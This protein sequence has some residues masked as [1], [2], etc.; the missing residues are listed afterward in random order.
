MTDNNPTFNIFGAATRDDIHVG[1]ISTDRG[2][3]SNVSICEANELAKKDPGM[4][5]IFRNREEIKYIN[6]NSVNKLTT[7]DLFED[8]GEECGIISGGNDEVG[9]A[10]VKGITVD[11]TQ[12]VCTP[13]VQ[14]FGGGGLGVLANP[15]IGKDGS[16]MSIDADWPQGFGY[17]YKPVARVVDPCGIG[18]GAVLKVIMVDGTEED[19][20]EYIEYEDEEDFED[21]KIC[22]KN[23]AGYGKRYNIR[24]SNDG[25]WNPNLYFDGGVLTFEQQLEKYKDFLLN[26]PNPW[27]TTRSQFPTKTTTGTKVS[28]E[29]YD[30]NHWAWGS[31]PNPPGLGT[32][33]G[34][35][36]LEL[37]GRKPEQDGFTFWQKKLDKGSTEEEIKLEM[38]TMPEY[39]L[40]QKDGRWAEN[41]HAWVGGA[42]YKPDLKNF[43][44]SY[45]ISPIPMSNVIPSDFGGQEHYFEWDI[46]FP[47]KGEY[48]FR[49]QCDNEG[50]LYVDGE[51]Q[52]DYKLGSGGAGGAVLSPPEETK[53]D[54]KKAGNHKIR[55]DLFNG[56]VMKKVAEQQ[57]LDALATSDEV[58]FDIQVATLYGASATIEG[59]DISYGKTYGEAKKV[60][61]SVTKKVEYGRVY[62]VKITSDTIRTE[63]ST[64]T[65]GGSYPL[66]YTKLKDGA[67]RRINDR[68]LEYD[69]RASNI[70]FDRKA[71]EFAGAFT[72]DNV[73]GGTAKFSADGSSVEVQGDEVKVTLTYNWD[74][75]PRRSGRVLETIQIKDTVWRQLNWRA[76]ENRWVVESIGSHTYTVT[77]AGST[78]TTATKTIGGANNGAALRTKGQNVLQMEDIPNT[79]AG[80]GGEGV[81]WDDVII[82]ASQGRFFDINGL[83]AKYT[84]GDRPIE[85]GS[86]STENTGKLENIFNTA[87]Y[88]DKADRPL[89]K[90]N[91]VTT[92]DS[93]FVNR[94]GISPFDTGMKYESS[95]AGTY[96]IKWHNVKFPVSGEYD[97]GIGVDDNVRLRIR[98]NT[99]TIGTQV[100][101]K[102]DGFAVRG[103][104]KTYTG[105]SLYRRFIEAGSYT[106]EADLEQVEG[107]DL[108]YRNIAGED[109]GGNPMTLAINIETVFSESKVQAQKSWNQNPLGV[110]MTIE[111]PAPPIPQ[112]LPPK[113][114]G[115]CPPNPF[116]STRYPAE[117]DTWY[118]FI[119]QRKVYRYAVSPV[120]PYG[121]DNTS[122]GSKTHSNTWKIVAPYDGFYKIKAAADDSAVI[123]FDGEEVLRTVGVSSMAEHKFFVK[124]FNDEN[125]PKPIEHTLTV[126]VSNVGQ[127]IYDSID[128]RIFSTQGWSALGTQVDQTLNT[129]DVEFKMSTSTMYGASASIPELDMSIEKE[130]GV[131]K[132]V[133][134]TFTRKVEFDR[135]Y[136]VKIGSNTIRSESSTSTI[137]GSYPL[138]YTKLKD[139]ALRRIND[140]RLE[141]DDR[142]SN[143]GFDRKANE[144]AGAFT[145]DNVVGGT[146]KFS[147]DGSSVE[148]QGDEVKVTL[149][150][151]W[152]DNPR[153]SGRVLETIAI[154]DTVWRQLN[155]RESENRWVVESIGSHTYTVTLA[156]K[157]TSTSSKTI[158]GANNGAVLR[159]KG[160]NVLQM[161]D[162]PGTGAGGGGVGVYWD[163]VIVSCDQGRFF[164]INGL[165]A[166]FVLE[167]KTKKV[168]QGGIGSGTVKDGVIY[169]GPE[170]FHKN[171][172]GWGP[173]MNKASV[174]QNPLVANTQVVNYTWEN[175]D[176]PETGNYKIK[177]QNDAHADLYL[178]GEKIIASNFDNEVGVSDIDA[179]NFKGSGVFRSVLINEGKHTLTVGPPNPDLI[180]TLFK[181]PAGYEWHKNPSGFALEI[182]KDTKIVRKGADGKPITKSWKENPVMVSAHLIPPPC[183]RLVEGKGSIKKIIPIVPGNGYPIGVTTTSDSKY[184]VTLELTEIIVEDPG[185]NYDPEDEVIITGGDGDPVIPPFKPI[186]GGF[187]EIIDIPLP[188]RVGIVTTTIETPPPG[189][190]PGITPP[191]VTPPSLPPPPGTGYP[192]FTVTPDI[193]ITTGTGIG[194]KGTPVFT[195]RRTPPLV[196]PDRLLQVTD[197]VGLKQ[198]G[199]YDGKP[200]YGAIF[201]KE[202]IKYAGWYETAGQLVQVYDTLQESIDAMVTTPPSAIQRQGSDISSNDPRLNIPGTPDNLTY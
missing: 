81:Y 162:I 99:H 97:I 88:I 159:T 39:A 21:Y 90:T 32:I 25:E 140:R 68:R 46:D 130:Y 172:S 115:R 10:S 169:T 102:K 31:V 96:T 4:L 40:V 141:Y 133:S 18:A 82:S 80:G 104:A 1:Y 17:E 154:K 136:D 2:M 176:F 8:V 63:N 64:S 101:I 107:G 173:F 108:G 191:P 19:L 33:V 9:V 178:D 54:I 150:Y 78:T 143:I 62:D 26:A 134:E 144:F 171:F 160:D 189:T 49:F 67:L 27:W 34:N 51:K 175:V 195:P 119:D 70:G 57:K 45:A 179:A 126:D 74:D 163:D 158:G 100:D 3:V 187:G 93:D 125:P 123:K 197:L 183:P 151:N 139:G 94:Y 69:D 200:Y 5:F 111:A 87:E 76:R 58:K 53:V 109:V 166:K 117:G 30:V 28:R 73:V 16:V 6:I 201:Y 66:V 157:T 174:S 72:I 146:A 112:E 153:R 36:Y 79:D 182:L 75:N 52:G 65:I 106:I 165:N 86:T 92:R 129:N 22:P 47:H 105:S 194:F 83:T 131:G 149:T 198:T 55:V 7:E 196:D 44:N 60:N 184:D 23:E 152:D 59:L 11:D 127:E 124:A 89:W 41:D 142:A 14:V 56:Q 132:D 177:F 12:I 167:R 193:S 103:D 186:T 71:N 128:K 114:E 135:V 13:E 190:P 20:M 122:G 156:G 116:W 91:L 113:Q 137:G 188:P 24:G 168:L 61:E 85:R 43:M 98:S 138:V 42:F 35:L 199:Y 121:K 202:G 38:M 29:K 50:T 164:D 37:F 155:W 148:V 84:L 170:L 185:I 15:I 181:Q 180:D 110:A 48:I 161:E 120:I 145:I 118:P 192:G 77:L 147:A 95:M